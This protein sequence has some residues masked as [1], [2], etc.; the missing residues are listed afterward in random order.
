M[1]VFTVIIVLAL[2]VLGLYLAARQ[3]MGEAPDAS[4][5]KRFQQSPNFSQ[6]RNRFININQELVDK[7]Q[8]EGIPFSKLK[9]FFLESHKRSPQKPLP[10]V[11][12][13]F[14][15]FLSGDSPFKVI[16]F[17]HSSL[18]LNMEGKLVLIDPVFGAAA[19]L[20]FLKSR[21]QHPVV[22]AKDLPDIDYLLI[23]HD[24]YDHLEMDTIKFYADKPVTFIVPLGV[25]SYLKGWGVDSDKIIELDWWQQ[26]E[27]AGI[28]FTATPSQHFSGRRFGQ[29]HQTLWASWVIQSMHHNVFFSGDTGFHKEFKSIGE[30]LGP[31][32]VA[33][34]ENG[35][36]NASWE[37]IHLMPEMGV[38]AF[39]LLNAKKLFPIHW[40]MF[41]LS[42]HR[43]NDPILT[44]S[45]LAHENGISLIT[46]KIGETVDL[47][48]STQT[49][50]PWWE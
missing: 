5:L 27:L 47:N 31:F 16:W 25:S 2:V 22:T 19:P 12:P 30:K 35:Q 10:E 20:A 44:M 6:A 36:Y 43:W 15:D 37:A 42:L 34:I 28:V 18:L 21:F 3:S 29:G 33:F 4:A 9:S 14:S 1:I 23:S 39:N 7:K 24:H 32:D 46:P 17:G 8:A 41:D 38:E 13:D 26:A 40:G 48:E 49:F 45:Q 50:E 11:T